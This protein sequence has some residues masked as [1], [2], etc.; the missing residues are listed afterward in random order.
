Q[1]A[2]DTLGGDSGHV[3]APAA[4][5]PQRKSDHVLKV[6]AVGGRELVRHARGGY[7]S[8]E[9]V[10]RTKWRRVLDWRV[11]EFRAG[12]LSCCRP[13]CL[14]RRSSVAPGPPSRHVP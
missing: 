3:D 14:A 6:F 2:H 8:D 4:F 12:G 9:N 11:P 5:E 7:K 1:V 13:S 10:T